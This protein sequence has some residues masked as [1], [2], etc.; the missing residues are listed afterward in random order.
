MNARATARTGGSA[1][2][3]EGMFRL[4]DPFS[5][6]YRALKER[7]VRLGLSG[8]LLLL[9][10]AF[11]TA[12]EL[13]IFVP[14][15]ATFRQRWLSDRVAAARPASNSGRPIASAPAAVPAGHAPRV[16]VAPVLH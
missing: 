15:M 3:M 7:R 10:I 11:V 9:T 1:R 8:K 13:A 14:S 5:G 16:P 12:A 6:S 4:Q 2:G